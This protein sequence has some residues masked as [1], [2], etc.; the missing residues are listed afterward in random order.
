MGQLV[1]ET[2]EEGSLHLGVWLA[3]TLLHQKVC[4]MVLR[5]LK[6]V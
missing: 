2:I 3:S 4:V 6:L 5:P 1:E